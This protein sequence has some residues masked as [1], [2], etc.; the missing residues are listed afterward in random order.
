VLTPFDVKQA[1]ISGTEGKSKRIN[2]QHTT[3]TI[4]AENYTEE[5]INLRSVAN[6]DTTL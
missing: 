1:D 5:L 2:E 4:P 6:L 3:R